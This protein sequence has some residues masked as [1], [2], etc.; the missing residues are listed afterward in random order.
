MRSDSIESTTVRRPAH[1]FGSVLNRVFEV[2]EWL[3]TLNN[4]SEDERCLSRQ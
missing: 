2:D 1:E 4:R 3:K